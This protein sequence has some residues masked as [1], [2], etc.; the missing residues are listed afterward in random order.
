MLTLAEEFMLFDL[1][2]Y[3]GQL[4]TN[5]EAILPGTL[6][7][8]LALGNCVQLDPQDATRLIAASGSANDALLQ[9]ALDRVSSLTKVKRLIDYGAVPNLA[10][11]LR[12]RL[13]D[14][15]LVR[16]EERRGGLLWLGHKTVY[17][18]EESPPKQELVQRIRDTAAGKVTP[19][20]QTVV[21]M[22]L[23]D[24][25]LASGE[26]KKQDDNAVHAFCEKA[27]LIP[28]LYGSDDSPDSVRDLFGEPMALTIEALIENMGE[29][30]SAIL[31]DEALAGY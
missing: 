18:V 27:G 23:L 6:L 5:G 20:P 21:F 15:K 31:A 16:Q 7:L 17:M 28:I 8:Q 30:N 2:T 4:S 11:R 26:L 10:D 24:L 9:E 19:A 3:K 13:L 22:Y 29:L 1:H 25:C 12:Q 14:Q